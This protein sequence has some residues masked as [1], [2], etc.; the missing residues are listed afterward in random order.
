MLP[1]DY[2][3]PFR[4]FRNDQIT[5]HDRHTNHGDEDT[6]SNEDIRN[7]TVPSCRWMLFKLDDI[8]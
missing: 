7:D 8:E 5:L 1:T 4:T 2:N 6:D 3:C